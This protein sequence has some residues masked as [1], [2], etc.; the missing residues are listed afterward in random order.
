MHDHYFRKN[1]LANLQEP[2]IHKRKNIRLNVSLLRIQLLSEHVINDF[3]KIL[4]GVAKC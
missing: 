3:V 2:A 1:L 4:K